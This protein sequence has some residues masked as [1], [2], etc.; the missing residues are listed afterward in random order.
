VPKLHILLLT[1]NVAACFGL[2]WWMMAI[3]NSECGC[4]LED[5]IVILFF[6][7]KVAL[8]QGKCHSTEKKKWKEYWKYSSRKFI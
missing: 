2:S 4:S 5:E 6:L 8:Q 1:N 7:L 3:Y